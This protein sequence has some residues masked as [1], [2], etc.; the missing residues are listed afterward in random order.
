M[1]LELTGTWEEIL[2][3]M[4]VVLCM[5]PSLAAGGFLGETRQAVPEGIIPKPVDNQPVVHEGPSPE[6]S[7]EPSPKKELK[8]NAGARKPKKTQDTPEE[9]QEELKAELTPA[10]VVA[11][12]QKTIE[13]LQAAYSGGK[14]KEVFALLA[15]HGNGAKSFR[16]LTAEAFLPIRKAIDEGALA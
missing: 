6:M 3:Q 16:E 12:R 15:E 1:K 13:D 4:R 7:P 14:Q 9:T 5:N 8:G 2:Q 11:V 10:E